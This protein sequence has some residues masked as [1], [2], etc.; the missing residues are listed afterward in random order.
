VSTTDLASFYPYRSEYLQSQS[1]G[2]YR[3]SIGSI[4]SISANVLDRLDRVWGNGPKWRARCPVHN[5]RRLSLSIR[6]TPDNVLIHCFAGCD[7]QSICAAIGVEQRDLFLD[8]VSRE[9]QVQRPRLVATQASV[10]AALDA[11]MAR[12]KREH[13]PITDEIANRILAT[14]GAQF[15]R[16]FPRLPEPPS[17]ES[18][19][20]LAK[21]LQGCVP[22]IG[23][24]SERYLET[25]GISAEFARASDVRHHQNWY[26]IA[27]AV[28]ALLKNRHGEVVGASG[29][30]LLNRIPKAMTAGCSAA[31]GGV[32]KTPGAAAAPIIAIVEGVI[33]ALSIAEV[34]GVP[35]IAIIGAAFPTDLE[36]RCRSKRVLVAAD[37][38]FSNAKNPG[39]KLAERLMSSLQRCVS[40]ERVKWPE[41]IKDA[42]ELLLRDR[43]AL[44]ALFMPSA[45]LQPAPYQPEPGESLLAYAV[46]RLGTKVAA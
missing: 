40:V 42:N 25:R 11:V 26:G 37:N 33:D 27:P 45:P 7:L 5:G 13:G 6:E 24:E 8:S 39:E 18:A 22:V 46:L 9:T 38:D 32:F 12:Y 2:P 31:A 10:I 14:V 20:K 35:S 30:F 16:Q 21:M 19:T 1:N 4:A 17:G 44:R 29:R 41:G 34:T 23:T 15:G 36:A 3:P 43:E 28:V